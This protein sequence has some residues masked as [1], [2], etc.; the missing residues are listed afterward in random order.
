MNWVYLAIA[1]LFEIGWGIGLKFTQ[2]WT[3]PVPSLITGLLMILSFFFLS[4]AVKSL[5]IGTAYAVWTGIGTVGAAIAGI[6]LFNEP[7]DIIRIVCIVLV[8]LGIV[9]LKFS[10]NA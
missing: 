2:G 10:S 9:G 7:K 8:V 4:L 1:G 3:R 6:V 5:P